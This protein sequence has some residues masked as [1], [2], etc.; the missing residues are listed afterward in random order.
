M[1]EHNTPEY[2]TF[3]RTFENYR[4]YK[5]ILV[6]IIGAIVYVILQVAIFA[7]FGMAYGWNT[8]FQLMTQGYEA[9]NSEAGSYIGYLSVA[10]FLPSLYIATKIVHHGED[11]TGNYFLNH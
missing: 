11:G 1:S 5:P 2:I 4:W 6:F 8:I 9:L 7:I 3:P 10:I